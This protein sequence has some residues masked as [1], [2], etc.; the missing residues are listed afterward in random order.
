MENRRLIF[1]III[2]LTC[3]LTGCWDA[4]EISDKTI[5]TLVAVDKIDGNVKFTLEFRPPIDRS[6]GA[7]KGKESDIIRGEGKNFTQASNSYLRRA[8]KDIFLGAVRA[9][10]FTDNLAHEGIEEYLNRLRGLEEYRRTITIFSTTAD[11]D[12]L[13]DAKQLDYDNIGYAIEHLN[14]QLVKNGTLYNAT[15]SIVLENAS[16]ENVGYLLSNLDI[17]NEKIE[18]T[19]YSVFKNNKKVGLI[20]ETDMKGV[21]FL[22]LEKSKGEYT[23]NMEGVDIAVSTR[24]K[25]KKSLLLIKMKK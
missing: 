2:L 21:N 3:I 15:V 14:A 19:G 9:L 16:T 6:M 12:R 18:V 7:A 5:I 10:I 13:L 4:K 25:N 24:I 23:I 11:M 17:V 1:I 20:P 8:N 22:I